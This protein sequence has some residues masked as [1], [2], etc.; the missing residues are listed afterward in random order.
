MSFF[1]GLFR[2]SCPLDLR[3]FTD[4]HCHILPGVDDGIETLEE[5]LRVLGAY[6]QAGVAAVWLTPHIMEDIPNTSDFLRLRFE[7]LRQAYSGSVSLHLSAENMLDSVF[8]ERLEKND[9]LT[10]DGDKVLVETSYFNPPIKFNETLKQVLERGFRPLLAHPE[11][12][13]YINDVAYY[14]KLKNNGVLFQG[15]LMSLSGYYGPA[16]K[17]KAMYLLKNGLYDCFGS[18]LHH[19]GH[20]DVIKQ[21]Q[22]RE[23]EYNAFVSV[24]NFQI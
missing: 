17:Q 20:I 13:N 21:M 22:L 15:N 19:E 12:Y 3:G 18:D 10:V 2:R 24:L 11:R 4:Y 6:E 7:E 16:V 8:Q 9:I 1:S 5:S 14:H 23:P